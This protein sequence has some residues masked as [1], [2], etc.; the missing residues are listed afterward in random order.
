MRS[1]IALYVQW[2]LVHAIN[3]DCSEQLLEGQCVWLD[4]VIIG[5]VIIL[6]PSVAPH[7]ANKVFL[8]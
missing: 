8:L 3:T 5:D 6:V 7:N 1:N 4:N 2:F